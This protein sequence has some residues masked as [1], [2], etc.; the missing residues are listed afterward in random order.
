MYIHV[1]IFCGATAQ[2]ALG[3]FIVEAPSSDRPTHTW[4]YSSGRVISPSQRP[5]LTQHKTK[6]KRQISV[7]LEGIEPSI[8]AIQPPHT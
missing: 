4:Y 7:P 8:P 5:L 6:H 1:N 2:P 3:R